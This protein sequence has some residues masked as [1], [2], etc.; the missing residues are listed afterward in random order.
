M[1]KHTARLQV[2]A[3]MTIFG[4][5]GVFVNHIPLPSSLIALARGC[6]G[7][8]FLLMLNALRGRGLPKVPG[9][10]LPWL[11][12]SGGGLGFNWILLFEAYRYTTVATATLCYYLAPILIILVSP[13]VLKER[14]SLRRGLCVLVALAGMVCISGVLQTG[15]P[16]ASELTGIG[17]GLGAAV[18]YATVVLLNRRL[19]GIGAFDR[20]IWQ[21]GIS[22]VIVAPYCLVTQWGQPLALELSAGL[23]LLLV[24]VLHTGVTYYMYFSA[25]PHL[26]GQTVA[27]LSYV[28]PVVA[29]LCSVLILRQPTNVAELVGAVLIIGAALVSELPEKR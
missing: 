24:G 10:L 4:T 18:L 27:I 8:L 26:P 2:I 25:L 23:L 29:V 12:L 28:D 7:T 20:T 3:A 11:L 9:R 17:L 5:I 1:K 13:L 6:I 16:S 14:L 19:G 15:I 21:L 22:A